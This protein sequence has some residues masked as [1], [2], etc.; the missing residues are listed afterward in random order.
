L[1]GAGAGLGKSELGVNIALENSMIGARVHFFALEAEK[2]E[3]ERRIKFRL[4][5]DVYFNEILPIYRP[6]NFDFQDWYYGKLDSMFKEYEGKVESE[7]A[8]KMK[9]LFTFYR[10]FGE[11]TIGD[12]EKLFLAL[13]DSTDLVIVDHL[14]FF[15]WEEI[16]DNR[17]I[18]SIM[19]KFRELALMTGKPVVLI[20]HIRKGDR[21]LKQLLPLLEDLHGSSEIGKIAVKALTIGPADIQS[22]QPKKIPTY[23]RGVKNRP[24]GHRT[25]F[26]ALLN[27]DLERNAYDQKYFLGKEGI[28]GKF[29]PIEEDDDLPGWAKS[30]ITPQTPQITRVS[31]EKANGNESQA[32][33][34]YIDD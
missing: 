22:G 16:D 34:P 6:R 12:F 7:M 25:R 29:N 1:I 24:G 5:S 15:D 17:A 8:E 28:D 11:F 14:H 3:I 9:T 27:F 2:Y 31:K 20:V 32:R 13:Q 23:M 33:L 26:T 30:A 19:K 10:E 18:K 21:K 4:L